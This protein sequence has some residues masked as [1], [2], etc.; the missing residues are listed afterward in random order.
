MPL[1]R[2][3]AIDAKGKKQSGLIEGHSIEEVKERLRDQGVMISS[4]ALQGSKSRTNLH[5][6]AL[7]SFTQQLSQLSNAGVPLYESMV[8]IEEQSRSEK[9]HSILL[10]LCEQIK[11]GTSLSRAMASFPQ[12]FDKLYCGMIAAGESSGALPVVLDRLGQ[13]LNRR[14]KL[15]REISTAM[16][17]PS[18]LAVFALFV[19]AL[20]LGFV[21]PS[22][23]DIFTGRELNWF[24]E[25]VLSASRFVR[26]WWWLYLPLLAMVVTLV[27]FQIR[28]PSGRRWLERVSLR[29]PLFGRLIK[30]ACLSRFCRTM[31]TLQQGGLT[32]IDSLRIARSVMGNAVLEADM[33]QAEQKIVEGQSLSGSLARFSWIP[34][35]VPRMVRI[36]EESGTLQSMF[37]HIADMYE[38]EMEKNIERLLALAQPAILL[39]MGLVI[40]TVLMA[41]LL[42]LA[43]VSS[44]AG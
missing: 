6:D 9:Y 26:H 19:I 18:L 20:L 38:E 15:K 40:G 11:S 1:Y 30:Q 41:V 44:L 34:P 3:H 42:P 39:T 33:L 12:S 28:S 25:F 24:T 29:L 35:L 31:S 10:S 22:M 14:L 27:I 21:I 7:V 4:L 37:G 32:M 8:A 23:E 5:G 17:Y 13:F 16:I 36:G 2:Y 43:D